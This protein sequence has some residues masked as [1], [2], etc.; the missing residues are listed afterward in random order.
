MMADDQRIDPQRRSIYT[1]MIVIALAVAAGRIAVVTSKEGDTAFLSANDRSR[2]ATVASL[3]ERGTYAIDQQIA[4]TD[5]VKRN[6]RPWN[7]IDKVRHLG[8]DGKQH[9]YS[10]KPPLFP[11]L[12]AGI[13]WMVRAVT[14]MTLTDQPIYMARILLALVNLPLLAIFLVA[15][16]FSIDRLVRNDW[17]RH[18]TVASCCFGT[19]ML[20]F[21]IS[22]N[23]HLV[24]AAAT[25]LT[26]SLY[27]LAVQRIK[28]NAA[29]D[30]GSPIS[31]SLWMVAGMAAAMATANELPAMSMMVFW[32]ILFAWICRRSILPMLAGIAIVG[33]GFFGTN[34]LAH[35][36]LRPAYAHRGNGPVIERYDESSQ[37]AAPDSTLVDAVTETLRSGQWIDAEEVVRMDASDEPARWVVRVRENETQFALL[38]TAGAWELAQWDDWYEYPG[39]YWRPENLRGVDRG[40]PSRLVYFL[41]MTV[42]HHGLFSLTPIW[43]LMPFGLVVGVM[44]GGSEQRR[45]MGAVLVATVVCALFYLARPEIDRNYGGVSVCFRWLLWLAPLWLLAIGLVLARFSESAWCRGTVFALLALSVF[46]MATSLSSP[47]QSPWLYRFW[48]FLGWIDA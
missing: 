15:T 39:T 37:A 20:P 17:A 23:N 38:R 13:Y 4:I 41:H 40:E 11:T 9:Y 43:L 34:W 7:T 22:L 10:S 31:W 1:L 45:M 2:W 29:K 24:A 42:G 30:T 8:R 33:F 21:S 19:M 25:A 14:G 16:T 47:W 3:V 5:P 6:R 18:V 27:V 46:S 12:V 35:Q 36:S 28:S 26:M 44:T 32:F 48:Q